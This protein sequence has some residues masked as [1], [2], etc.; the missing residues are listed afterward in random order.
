MTTRITNL[1]AAIAL[2]FTLA[3]CTS[4]ASART[5]TTLGVGLAVSGGTAAVFSEVY[6]DR[7]PL[8]GARKSRNV[9][10]GVLSAGALIAIISYV[11]SVRIESEYRDERTEEIM[12][13]ILSEEEDS[14]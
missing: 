7:K 13:T 11:E 9:S 1:T 2:S 12:L 6:S 4:L 3:G 5:G 14:E 10:L 8:S